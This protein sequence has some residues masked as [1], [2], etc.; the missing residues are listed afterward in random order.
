MEFQIDDFTFDDVHFV[1][2]EFNR[3]VAPSSIML[4]C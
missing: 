1:V 3:A 4:I 2:S